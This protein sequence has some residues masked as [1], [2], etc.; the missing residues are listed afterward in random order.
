MMR[1]MLLARFAFAGVRARVVVTALGV[2][3]L[4]AGAAG[5]QDA[6]VTLRSAVEQA[7]ARY[8]TVAVAE[9]DH[10]AAAAGIEIARQAYR[11][12]IDGLVQLNRATHANVA[13]LLLPQSVIAPISGPVDS[14]A[15][16]GSV[17]GTAIGAL[18]TWK[19]FD[20]GAR[21][22]ALRAA[23]QDAAATQAG[24]E[25]VRLDMA[26]TVADAYLSALAGQATVT[27]AQAAVTRA[28]TL[29]RTVEALVSAGL[30]P[31]V[32]GATARAE[33][34]AAVVQRIQA[35]RAADAA[36]ALLSQYTGTSASLVAMPAAP[37][38]A[39]SPAAGAVPAHPTLREREAAVEAARM[40]LDAARHAADPEIAVQGTVYGRGTGVLETNAS[41]TGAD[42]LGFDAAN[43]AVGVSV[44]VP[45]MEWA[46]KRAREAVQSAH[47]DAARARVDETTRDLLRRR[48]VA[49]QDVTAAEGLARQMPLLVTAARA[50]QAQASARYEAGLSSIMEV[51]DAERRLSQAEMDDGL[52]QLAVWRAR[53]ALTALTAD[54]AGAFVNALPGQP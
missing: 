32:D 34:A 1:R 16:S 41:G 8:P 51:A 3:V 14:E 15:S 53:L 31:G 7:V 44:T 39:S 25:R 30:R 29:V 49:A 52:A 47:L 6:P 27:A 10:A 23:E 13:G 37:A 33:Q 50:A 5:A 9:A 46:N 4:M 24:V 54:G 38:S 2:G 22:T 21:A 48:T 28:D 42:G 17:W 40:R 18:V 20:F 26:A 36:A 43:W 19:P 35:R 11:P 45:M 12:R